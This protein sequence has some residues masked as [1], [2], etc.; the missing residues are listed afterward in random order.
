VAE[1]KKKTREI[2]LCAGR[3]FHGSELGRKS[4]PAPFEMTVGGVAAKMRANRGCG[5]GQLRGGPEDVEVF[6]DGGKV[7]VAGG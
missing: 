6:F 4:R 7:F 3:P 2:P 1:G 5:A